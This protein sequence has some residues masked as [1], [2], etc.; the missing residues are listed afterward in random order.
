MLDYY[1]ASG[2]TMSNDS[3]HKKYTA[4]YKDTTMRDAVAAFYSDD[5]KLGYGFETTV[6]DFKP[7]RYEDGK[8]AVELNFGD[9]AAAHL[10]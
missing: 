8:A 6:D 9:I 4:Y 1:K 3:G 10:Q 2:F 5:M 7:A